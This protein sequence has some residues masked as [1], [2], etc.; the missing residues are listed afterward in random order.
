MT[1]LIF[2]GLTLLF[3]PIF[4][5]ITWW[6]ATRELRRIEVGIAAP[7]HIT[8]LKIFRIVGIVMTVLM[9][10]SLLAVALMFA[11]FFVGAAIA[12]GTLHA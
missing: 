8:E 2:A 7:E 4:A 1:V 5:P 11:L 3:A 6:L 10:G 9:I 12:G